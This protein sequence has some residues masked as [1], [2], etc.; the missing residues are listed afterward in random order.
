[1][2][3][4]VLADSG[5]GSLKASRSSCDDAAARGLR[6]EYS[7]ADFADLMAADLDAS[8][9]LSR[10]P[11]I[12][13]TTGGGGMVGSLLSDVVVDAGS[14]KSANMTECVPVPS[15]EH[16][17][18]I[19]G[20]QGIVVVCLLSFQF[21]FDVIFRQ[22]RRSHRII[23]GDIKENW[24]SGGQKSPTGSRGRAP[25]GGLGDEVP[26]KLK[27]FVKLHIIFAL[28]YNKNSCC[29]Y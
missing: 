3:A 14:R 19:V 11:A 20:R 4:V 8:P 15:S 13:I 28:K 24:E 23:G 18:E 21:L 9:V 26:P 5:R 6:T 17:A 27:L 10:A 29:C 1:M 22:R 2:S 7:A 12:A 16:V 25:V